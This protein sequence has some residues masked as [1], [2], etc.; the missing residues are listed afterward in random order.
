MHG[1]QA[2]EEEEVGGTL[3]RTGTKKGLSVLLIA[4]DGNNVSDLKS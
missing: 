2:E 1:L 3:L 4:S